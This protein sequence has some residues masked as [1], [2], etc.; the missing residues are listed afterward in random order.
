M[1]FG[2]DERTLEKLRS[3]FARY[4]PVQEVIIYGSRA[5]GTYVPSSDIDLVVKS[6][7]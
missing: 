7:P 1:S 4:E 6:F 2:L 5:K 3:V